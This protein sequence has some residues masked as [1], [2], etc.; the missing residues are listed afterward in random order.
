MHPAFVNT[1]RMRPAPWGAVA[2]LLSIRIM[3]RRRSRRLR[4][5][6]FTS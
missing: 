6:H 5:R 3:L 1:P 2:L 4:R